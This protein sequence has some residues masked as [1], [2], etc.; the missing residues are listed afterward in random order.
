[1]IMLLLN[2]CFV[3]EDHV[4]F[5]RSLRALPFCKSL[6]ALPFCKSLRA[7]LF[8]RSLCALLYCRSPFCKSLY[9][10]RIVWTSV[11]YRIADITRACRFGWVTLFLVG[12]L[13]PT[14]LLKCVC[15]SYCFISLY[16][17]YIHV[18]MNYGNAF[19]PVFTH[20]VC[21]THYSFNSFF[22]DTT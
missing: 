19:Y 2:G 12:A 4:P 17:I 18:C 3:H 1:M 9:A 22:L 15:I 16:V 20:R 6:H 10:Y 5:C 13:S 11:P 21:M 7:L 8:C 14:V